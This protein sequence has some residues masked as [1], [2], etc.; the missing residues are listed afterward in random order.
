MLCLTASAAAASYRVEIEAP[1]P[2]HDLL[3]QHLDLVRDQTRAD[4]SDDQ[5]QFLVDTV[6]LQVQGLAS[7]EGYF[8]P[9]VKV[10]VQQVGGQRVVRLQVEAN[11][12][13]VVAG[14]AIDIVG[15]IR[16]EAAQRADDTMKNW[17]LPEGRPFRQLDWD[18]AKDNALQ[19]LQRQRYAAARI[20]RSEA[21][22]D[23]EQGRARLSVQY[24]SGP[25]FSLGTLL[26]SGIKRYPDSIIRNVNPLQPGEDYTI[27]RLL[28]LQRQIQKTPYFS[29]VIVAL[30]DDPAHAELAPVKVSVTE[31][32]VQRIRTGAGYSSDTG[33]HVEGRYSYYNL[34]QRAW[35]FDGQVKLEQQRQFAALGIDLPPDAQSYV[36][37]ASA[38]YERTTLQGIDLHS[39]RVGLKR[40]RSYERYDTAF[41]LDYFLADLQQINNTPLPSDTIAAP[42]RHRALVPGF[43]WTRREVDNPMFP[44][45]GNVISAQTGFAVNGL[46]TDQSFLRAYGRVKEYLP[47]GER[48]S[49]VL[50]GELG[51][52]FTVGG[53]EAIPAS[54][55]FRAGG[56]DSVRGYANQSIGNL[57]NGTVFPT[58]F[59]LTASTEY[60]HWFSA[61]WGAALFYDVGS[62]ADKWVDR[63]IYHGV[64]IGA[65][66]RSPVGPV[67]VDLAHGIEARKMRLHV[68]LGIAF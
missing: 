37:G 47:V 26:I 1:P 8:T 32:P 16:Q 58:K 21:L 67:N 36:N 9:S 7:T 49:I 44:R 60:Q 5:F 42:G 53:G 46:I 2:L 39:A 59:L 31:F 14:T 23:P 38:S 62:A 63:K 19:S 3:E 18:S 4:L 65:R 61:Q 51:A 27:E 33:A 12:R 52:V 55:L 13:T 24:D 11:R 15:A 20:T 28:E 64:G 40:A 6:G 57:Q 25:R 29:N 34:L 48:D 66:W 54:L 17:G 50:R 41:S 56:S 22:I 68:S 10:A 30:D 43:A 45:R 35:V